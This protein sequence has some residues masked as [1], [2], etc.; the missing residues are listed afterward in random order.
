[1]TYELFPPF[2]INRWNTDP[3][4]LDIGCDVSDA[5]KVWEYG[6]GQ[7]EEDWIADMTTTSKVYLWKTSLFLS[8][9]ID[10]DGITIF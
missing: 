6:Y 5:N 10:S 1:M 8:Y 4:V 3:V 7:Y 2:L 9:R